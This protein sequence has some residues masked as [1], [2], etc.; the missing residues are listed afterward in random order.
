MIVTQVLEQHVKLSDPTCDDDG[1]KFKRSVSKTVR[2]RAF[3]KGMCKFGDKCRF[4][5]IYQSSKRLRPETIE[6]QP[7]PKISTVAFFDSAP[8]IYGSNVHR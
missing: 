6:G 5:H 4:S 3:K 7:K 8:I 2:C 1:K